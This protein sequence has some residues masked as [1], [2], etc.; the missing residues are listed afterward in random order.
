MERSGFFRPFFSQLVLLPLPS[1][2][3]SLLP[4]VADTENEFAFYLTPPCCRSD[5]ACQKAFGLRLA[6]NPSLPTL[7][8]CN[9]P[10]SGNTPGLFIVFLCPSSCALFLVRHFFVF[11]RSMKLSQVC[12]HFPCGICKERPDP[13]ETSLFSVYCMFV[14]CRRLFF[15]VPWGGWLFLCAHLLSSSKAGDPL[16]LT[17]RR[18]SVGSLKFYPKGL[19]FP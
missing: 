10:F 12:S 8:C 15:V 19:P 3:F 9:F 13:P 2:A 16:F 18:E 1:S 7:F 4:C 5:H 11:V 6:A 17:T 14:W